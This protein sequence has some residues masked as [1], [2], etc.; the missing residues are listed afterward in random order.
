MSV[1][2]ALTTTKR[3]TA[4]TP[5]LRS[6]RMPEALL[7]IRDL[8][9][10]FD[11]P[12]G[13]VLAVDGVSLDVAPG[14]VV[15][16]VGESGCGKSVT[17]LS[18]MGLLAPTARRVGG[19]IRFR[20][21]PLP[22]DDERAMRR[23]RGAEIA[24]IFQ[25][26]MTA[27]NPVHRVA[28][29]IGESLRVHEGLSRR[30]ARQRAIALMD[31]V[32]I[33]DPERRA[34]AYPHEL[35]GG[36]RQRVVIAS[37]LAAGPDLLLADEPTTALD[38]TIQAQI[39][40]LLARLAETRQMGVLLITHDLSVVAERAARV[41][42]MYAGRVVE[43]GPAAGVIARPAHPY[44]QGLLRSLPSHPDNRGARRLPTI[45]GTVPPALARPSGCTFRDRC[46]RADEVCGEARPTVVAVGEGHSAAC[47]RLDDVEGAA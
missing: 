14:E 40:D 39:L 23:L 7:E 10:A 1:R 43:T 6:A 8:A 27:L 24:M 12:E 18:T 46:P 20:G 22:T 33:P 9:V 17:A 16:V 15:G 42:V 37:A 41:V 4:A 26:P 31:E 32:G 34:L 28:D 30:D 13:R 38:V 44:A 35:S 5:L 11:T 2:K 36:M 25:E 45:G 19:E 47:V 3:P 21:A 29:Q